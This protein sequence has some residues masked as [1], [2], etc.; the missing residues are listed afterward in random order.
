M[1]RK[2]SEIKALRSSLGKWLMHRRWEAHLVFPLLS[3]LVLLFVYFATPLTIQSLVAPGFIEIPFADGRKIGIAHFLV[4]LGVIWSLVLGKS[5]LTITPQASVWFTC[6]AVMTALIMG[7]LFWM[8]GQTLGSRAS[9]IWMLTSGSRGAVY[10]FMDANPGLVN[11]AAICLAGLFLF[12]VIPLAF[13]RDHRPLVLTLVPSR[14]LMLPY[15]IMLLTA[16]VAWWLQSGGWDQ[17]E[18]QL[19]A[20]GTDYSILIM[21]NFIYMVALYMARVQY[22]SWVVVESESWKKSPWL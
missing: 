5:T 11:V 21:P 15:T 7:C 18:G 16:A 14:W 1:S 19:S 4:F 22:R 12:V 2:R 9:G 13:I 20:I 3:S 8:D 10:Q 6:I 17:T